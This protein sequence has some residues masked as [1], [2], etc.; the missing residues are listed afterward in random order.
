MKVNIQL[1][2]CSFFV[3]T[4]FGNA[5]INVDDLPNP[6]ADAQVGE[7]AYYTQP[8]G[9]EVFYQVIKRDGSIITVLAQVYLQG[10]LMN[11]ER[12]EVD[13]NIP[14]LAD[15]ASEYTM[16]EEELTIK[17]T[18]LPCTV[19]S[20]DTIKIW[21]SEKIPVYGQ[22]KVTIND[23]TTLELSSWGFEEQKESSEQQMDNEG[24]FDNDTN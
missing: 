22:V 19:F 14:P 18:V 23:A 24:A 8:H 7:W 21:T 5:E 9:N 20:N 15:Q 13:V 16:S 4:T 17:D 2:I 11:Q 12:T 6:L 3:F 10:K 1:M